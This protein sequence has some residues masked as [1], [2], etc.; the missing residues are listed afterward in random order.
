V[1]DAGLDPPHEWRLVV[2]DGARARFGPAL[3]PCRKRRAVMASPQT[4]MIGTA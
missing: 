1:L 3:D 2:A 4:S